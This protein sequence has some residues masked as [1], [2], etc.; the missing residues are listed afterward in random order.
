[1][2]IQR[3][4]EIASAITDLL[5][6]WDNLLE[7]EIR[8]VPESEQNQS[9]MWYRRQEAIEC[10]KRLEDIVDDLEDRVAQAQQAKL[11]AWVTLVEPTA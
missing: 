1:M 7:H 11:E 6:E 9:E 8:Y 5:I 3:E 4:F 10:H 2:N